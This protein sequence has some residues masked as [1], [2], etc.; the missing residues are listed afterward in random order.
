[1]GNNNLKGRSAARTGDDEIQCV[2]MNQQQQRSAP[3]YRSAI[4]TKALMPMGNS[5]RN[6]G[7]QPQAGPSNPPIREITQVPNHSNKNK[8]R[9]V[10]MNRKAMENPIIVD[11]DSDEGPLVIEVSDDDEAPLEPRPKRQRTSSAG[12]P[13]QLLSPAATPQPDRHV[14]HIIPKLESVDEEVDDPRLDDPRLYKPIPHNSKKMS[15]QLDFSDRFSE[16]SIHPERPKKRR[17]HPEI[18]NTHSDFIPKDRMQREDE[19]LV[20]APVPPAPHD[21]RHFRTWQVQRFMH[22]VNTPRTS[23]KTSAGAI[24]KIVQKEGCVAIASAVCGGGED[25]PDERPNPYNKAGTIVIHKEDSAPFILHGHRHKTRTSAATMWTKYYTVTDIQFS[26]V[27]DDPETSS[28]SI[29]ASC[30]NDKTV[31][32]WRHWD[33]L[34]GNNYTEDGLI[35]FQNDMQDDADTLRFEISPRQLAFNSKNSSVFAV[36]EKNVSICRVYQESTKVSASCRMARK[37][38]N[39]LSILWGSGPTSGYLFA[40]S[41]PITNNQWTGHHKCFDGEGNFIFKMRREES[42][43]SEEMDSADAMTLS[44]DGTTLAL[45][46]CTETQNFLY[47]YDAAHKQERPTSILTL[48][49]IT[50]PLNPYNDEQGA[51]NCA[52]YSPDGIYLAIGRSDNHTH[53]YDSRMLGR[54]VLYDFEHTGP[55][56]AS[57]G[58]SSY[59]VNSVGWIES[60]HHRLGLVTGGSDGCVR[61]WKPLQGANLENGRV[62]AEA[63][64]DIGCFSLGDRYERQHELVVGDADGTVYVWDGLYLDAF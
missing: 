13:R 46:T 15:Q 55:S 26:E 62:L 38:Y 30:A 27:P 57:P 61:M 6:Y 35:E 7:P 54:G 44:P 19:V 40:C 48:P 25:Y 34:P 49:K 16:L 36:A 17:P 14:M 18:L 33:K 21:V 52:S 42:R 43:K 63:G 59:G 37:G 32:I 39:T 4:N 10:E 8:R 56:R 60:R 3:S 50:P 41:E 2:G 12:G 51:V 29:L 22:Q 23:F 24:G 5:G 64:A 53:I 20:R 28:T 31:C 47:L 9:Q 45:F 1:M 58:T 11:S